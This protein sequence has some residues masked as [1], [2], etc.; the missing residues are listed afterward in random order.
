MSKIHKII[1]SVEGAKIVAATKYVGTPEMLKLLDDGICDFG[2]NRVDSFLE[3][4]EVLK[5]NKN[6]TWHFIG[7][8]QSRQSIS[9]NIL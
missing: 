6:I 9:P 1:E 7:T 2:E 5:E 4:Y 8:L 3:K